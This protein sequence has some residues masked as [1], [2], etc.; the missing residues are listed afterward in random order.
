MSYNFTLSK[1]GHKRIDL[2]IAFRVSIEDIGLGLAWA[3]ILQDEPLGF[4]RGIRS[5]T[6]A[7]DICK[8]ELKDRG[9]SFDFSDYLDDEA[10]AVGIRKANQLFAED[11]Q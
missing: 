3:S 1:D 10:I 6:K 5:K 4:I 11:I 2:R 8:R 9:A 7:L